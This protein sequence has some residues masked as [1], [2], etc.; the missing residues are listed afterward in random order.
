MLPIASTVAR[1]ISRNLERRPANLS[2][3]ESSSSVY[4]AES[5]QNSGKD[6]LADGLLL[7]L[8]QR[9]RPCSR[10]QIHPRSGSASAHAWCGS[11]TGEKA[12]EYTDA[13][14]EAVTGHW[15]FDPSDGMRI[16]ANSYGVWLLREPPGCRN[17]DAATD[18]RDDSAA[19]RHP[20][21]DRS[22]LAKCRSCAYHRL[23]F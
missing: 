15:N 20:G 13:L 4:A 2:F 21:T 7:W 11:P 17:T 6:G 8:R 19:Y 12:P 23:A 18:L 5:K 22:Q 9:G 1:K 10:S 16:D 3:M 14:L